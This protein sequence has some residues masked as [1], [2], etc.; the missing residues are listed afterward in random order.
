MAGED[1]QS[2]HY[3][4][5]TKAEVPWDIQKYVD[6]ATELKGLMTDRQL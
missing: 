6:K 1:A 5:R 2:V 4:Y 3:H